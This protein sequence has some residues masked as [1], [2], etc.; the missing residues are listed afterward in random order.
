MFL[1]DNVFADF[2]DNLIE[3][4]TVQFKQ[5]VYLKYISLISDDLVSD[6][7]EEDITS[8]LPCTLAIEDSP[9]DSIDLSQIDQVSFCLIVPF[10]R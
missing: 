5:I 4:H 1:V 3:A 6:V 2:L 8:E 9:E 7:M 10:F